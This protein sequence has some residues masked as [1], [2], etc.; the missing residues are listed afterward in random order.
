[1]P[2][3]PTTL[4]VSREQS[5]PGSNSL[6]LL[7]L[8][9]PTLDTL[10]LSDLNTCLPSSHPTDP[11]LTMS[12]SGSRQP[13]QPSI[14]LATLNRDGAD[15]A[16]AEARARELARRAEV[17]RREQALS[18]AQARLLALQRAP[19]A[20]P[21]PYGA[22]PSSMSYTRNASP[23]RGRSDIRPAAAGASA[24]GQGGQG[25]PPSGNRRSTSRGQA[26]QG[27]PCTKHQRVGCAVA[28]CAVA[29]TLG[30][31]LCLGKFN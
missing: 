19:G 5:R 31:P 6:L 3:C 26:G 7:F 14:P 13:A 2:R 20:Q 25:R 29:V 23:A 16:Q 4:A 27:V 15:R 22:G 28:S 8:L 12:S 24:S 30:V 10:P 11:S 18:D 1:M 17:G 9:H 21:P